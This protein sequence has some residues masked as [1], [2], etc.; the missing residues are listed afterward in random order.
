MWAVIAT[1]G[2]VSANELQ[3]AVADREHEIAMA[4]VD[5]D[6]VVLGIEAAALKW[7]G[8]DPHYACQSAAYFDAGVN[9][10]DLR[11]ENDK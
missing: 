8:I 11:V 9:Y 7:Q 5:H 2:R 3:G 6:D 4:A 10:R 1:R